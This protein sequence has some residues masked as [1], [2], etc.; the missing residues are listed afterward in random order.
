MPSVILL[1]PKYFPKTLGLLKKTLWLLISRKGTLE[2]LSQI[3]KWLKTQ[4]KTHGP[5]VETR[6]VIPEKMEFN[7]LPLFY[8]KQALVPNFLGLAMNSQQISKSRP[9]VF[10]YEIYS[11]KN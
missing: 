6:T 2:L 7:R 11:S 4:N 5:L 8:N 1:N 3:Q 10:F 9:H